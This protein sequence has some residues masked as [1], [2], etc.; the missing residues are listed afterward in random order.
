MFE[1]SAWVDLVAS[2][3]RLQAEAAED[4]RLGR[5]RFAASHVYDGGSEGGTVY[6][7]SGEIAKPV[8]QR[9]QEWHDSVTVR[10]WMD[11]DC[12]EIRHLVGPCYHWS[13]PCERFL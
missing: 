12:V 13:N 1:L 5:A 7:P 11:K 10:F 6:D 8:E 3:T 2:R 9:S 4:A